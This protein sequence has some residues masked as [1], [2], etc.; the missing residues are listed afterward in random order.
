LLAAPAA[1]QDDGPAELARLRGS[2]RTHQ[3]TRDGKESAPER[4][5]RLVI[6]GDRVM[7]HEPG[8][9][10]PV[11][12]RLAVGKETISAFTV[13]DPKNPNQSHVWPASAF[14]LSYGLYKLD[15]DELTLVLQ[16][17]YTIPKD[18]SD[19]EQ[20]RWV[21]RREKAK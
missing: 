7:I 8:R 15:G 3:S 17:A 10:E 18:F 5:V 21:L 14:R 16:S 2:W 12:M 6:D 11:P 13:D 20:V 4:G 1:G 9:K 19:R